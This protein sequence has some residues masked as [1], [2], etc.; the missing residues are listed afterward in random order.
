LRFAVPWGGGAW[1]G[2][3]VLAAMGF[4]RH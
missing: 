3:W 1:I 2:A 4:A